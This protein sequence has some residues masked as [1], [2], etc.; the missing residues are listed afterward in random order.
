MDTK[1]MRAC[2]P[3]LPP[4]GDEVV[5]DCLNEIDRLRGALVEIASGD[6]TAHE[7]VNWARLALDV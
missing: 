7:C 1:K 4:P 2:A 6:R 3:L 5:V